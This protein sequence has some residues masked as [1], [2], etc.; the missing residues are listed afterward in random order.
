M[1]AKHNSWRGS[2]CALLLLLIAAPAGWSAQR[3]AL[4]VNDVSGVNEPWPLVAGLPF[5][6][7][8]LNDPA[9]VRILRD[10]EE[11]PAQID[12][13]A[14]WRDGS[15]RWALAGFT[16]PPSGEYVAEFGADVTRQAPAAP[17]TV[18]RGEDGTLTVDTGA[19]TY[20]FH[21]DQLLPDRAT[22]NGTT[23]LDGA[24]DGAYLVD[25]QGRTARVCGAR[26][27]VTSELR[28]QG[29]MR[30]VVHRQGWYVTPKGR[31]V[32][33]AKMWFYFAAGSPYVRMTHSLVL[34]ENTNEWWV[35]DYGLELDTPEPAKEVA[36]ALSNP[37]ETESLSP[38]AKRYSELSEKQIEGLAN[39]FSGMYGRQWRLHTTAPGG[40]EVYMLQADY[41]QHLERRF[42]AV[43]GRV[44]GGSSASSR[45]GV[46]GGDNLWLHRWEKRMQVAGDWADGRWGGHAL[47]VVTPW[48]AQRFPKEIAFSPEGARVALWSG[49][50]GRSLDFRPATLVN[51]Q[52][53]SWAGYARYLPKPQRPSP[54]AAAG[55]A[56][57]STNA[58]GAAR[59]HDLWLMPRTDEIDA[60]TLKARATA[61][62]R[63]PR[64]LADPKWLTATEA[65]GWP[66]HPKDTQRF[67]TI[68]SKLSAFWRRLIVNG[69][70][71][72]R[73]RTGFIAWGQN[74]TLHHFSSFFRVGS[75]TD[76]GLR[77]HAWSLYARSGERR[78]WEYASRFNRFLGDWSLGHWTV[79]G[80]QKGVFV[81]WEPNVP[82]HWG[83]DTKLWHNVT[84]HG[85][86]HWQLEH[87]LTGD[88][89]AAH[90]TRMVGDA[91]KRV[92]NPNELRGI[93]ANNNGIYAILGI[94]ADL[95]THTGDE[96]YATM[97]R[98]L[99][100]QLIDP[101]NQR[102]RTDEVQYGVLY[103]IDRALMALYKYYKATG[104]EAAKQAIL[105]GLD[106][107][108]RLPTPL[109]FSRLHDPYTSQNYSGLLFSEAYRW[110]GNRLYLRVA[111]HLVQQARRIEPH[112]T[113]VNKQMHPF[114]ALPTAMGL[115]AEVGAENIEP[116]PVLMSEQPRPITFRKP[117][118]RAVTMSIFVVLAD[119]VAAETTTRVSVTPESAASSA[120]A[121]KNLR[122]E[123]ERQ[124]ATGEAG[125]K[126]D[127]RRRHVRLTVPADTPAGRYTLQLPDAVTIMVLES[128][129]PNI[130]FVPEK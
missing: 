22:V 113:A 60:Q 105:T 27:D 42:R 54:I 128:D 127:P 78:Y 36:F 112:S 13:A 91:Y 8:A 120:D 109:E 89:Y 106:Q 10:G 125:R 7:G 98:Q 70:Q 114:G 28:K 26:A 122:V 93:A 44:S 99:A 80:K 14:R 39:M 88:E 130:E 53:Q 20:T 38:R 12:V 100:D 18:Q 56:S 61:A 31:R 43:I 58:Q 37:L 103:K 3:F 102:G 104:D 111:N 82:F 72:R 47:T 83:H 92:W 110:T 23:V 63:A 66:M 77:W 50:S 64:V 117:A 76:Y 35:R 75:M 121:L 32:A 107:K 41:P 24:G 126:D 69:G 51:E 25:H 118:D 2:L 34:T 17:L 68:E 116:F 21:A 52:W 6:E 16:A 4:Q 57:E 46:A 29:P 19:A 5:P 87:Y 40:D 71:Y 95:Y 9:H 81:D 90:L 108:L 48:L 55:L 30:L 96:Q 65:L 15:I 45:R 85:I 59:T 115:V 84:G 124:N 101:S 74:P 67:G 33:R 97:A 1:S 119:D 79:G 62:A 129:A 86:T 123:V 11:I 49:R 94:L 73:R